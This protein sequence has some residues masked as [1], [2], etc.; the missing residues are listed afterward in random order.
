MVV[1]RKDSTAAMSCCGAVAEAQARLTVYSLGAERSV[2]CNA[3][4]SPQ[5]PCRHHKHSQPL[6]MSIHPEAVVVFRHVHQWKGQTS[7]STPHAAKCCYGCS[8][9]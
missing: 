1:C 6:D 4:R 8:S 9:T 5:P 2:A 3:V 7:L